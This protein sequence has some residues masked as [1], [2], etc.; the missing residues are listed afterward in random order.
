MIAHLKGIVLDTTAT[1]MVLDVHDI[2]YRVTLQASDLHALTIGTTAAF[3]IHTIVREDAFDLYGFLHTTDRDMFEH[4]LDVSGIGPK[5]AL[6]I[7]NSV[8]STA[9]GQAITQQNTAIIAGAGGVGKKTAEKIVRELEGKVKDHSSSAISFDE[10]AALALIS[11]GY[12]ER[13]ARDTLL[14]IHPSLT[15]TPERLKASLQMLG[16]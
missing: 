11:L 2:G 14:Q 15:T 5:T 1:Y 9:L 8:G 10:E 3:H 7:L 12:S 4:L 16:K 6:T 13:E